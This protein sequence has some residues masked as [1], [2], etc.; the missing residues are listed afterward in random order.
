MVII[1]KFHHEL[2]FFNSV[3]LSIN[4]YPFLKPNYN[5][6][7]RTR[8]QPYPSVCGVYTIYAA[9]HLFKYQHEELT[10]A[11]DGNVLSFLS[12]IH[13]IENNLM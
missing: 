1:A 7:V 9:F 10:G 12:R 5:Q 6:R 8:L 4:S 3:G 11:H 13:L 2:Y